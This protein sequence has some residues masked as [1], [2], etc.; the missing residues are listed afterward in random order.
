VS[1]FSGKSLLSW[2]QSTELVHISEM[3]HS[4]LLHRLGIGSKLD[5]ETLAIVNGVFRTFPR[6]LQRKK[7]GQKL[8]LALKCFISY[9]FSLII[10][11][12]CNLWTLYNL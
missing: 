6:R 8:K 2:A 12:L 11:Q 5:L 3:D 4:P 10:K 7:F 9:P 1:P